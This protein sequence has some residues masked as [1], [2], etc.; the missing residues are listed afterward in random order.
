MLIRSTADKLYGWISI[1]HNDV[2][3]SFFFHKVGEKSL[4]V[5]WQFSIVTFVAKK[6]YNDNMSFTMLLW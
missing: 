6:I 5:L 1:V 2:T 4:Q 3:F